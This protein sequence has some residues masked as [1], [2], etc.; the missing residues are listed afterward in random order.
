[1]SLVQASD[2]PLQNDEQTPPPSGDLGDRSA[3]PPPVGTR[4]AVDKVGTLTKLLQPGRES[5]SLFTSPA[6][7]HR[8]PP[9]PAEVSTSPCT[10]SPTSGPSPSSPSSAASSPRSPSA[11]TSPFSASGTG[12]HR[13]GCPSTRAGSRRAPRCSSWAL[14]TAARSPISRLSSGR[15]FKCGDC[16]RLPAARRSSA[17]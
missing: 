7:L 6:P 11:L 17:A 12:S 2:A 15:A 3:E 13:K 1:M 9:P 8:R 5:T 10:S 14:C 16:R 4:A